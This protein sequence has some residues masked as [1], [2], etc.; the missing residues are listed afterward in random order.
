MNAFATERS[1]NDEGS[2]EG[3]GPI[4]GGF[5]S[6]SAAV[7]CRSAAAT[8]LE[9][10]L[11]R[12]L[13]SA[14]GCPPVEF[15]LWD[16]SLVAG[17]R[18]RAISALRVR[19]RR[20]FWKLI[21]NPLLQFGEGYS[22]G[23][24]EV[25][26]DL[27]EMLGAVYR[28][29]ARAGRHRQGRGFGPAL[30]FLTGS[31]GG[32]DRKS[33]HHHYDIG[34]DFYRLWLDEEMVYTC[35]YFPDPSMSLWEAQRAK[36]DHVCRKVRLLAGETVVEAGCGWGGLALHMARRYGVKVRAFNISREQI[37]YARQ[38][39]RREGLDGRVEFIEDD[40]RDITG[41]YD[42]FVSVGMLE[43]VGPRN[44]SRLGRII[45]RC[46]HASGRGLIHSIGRD[47]S[48]P[49]NRWIARRIFP[50]A[51]PP[52]LQ[53]ITRVFQPYD[54]SI[55]DVENLRLHYAQTLRHWLARYERSV[56]QVLGMFDERFAR[57]WRLYLAGSMAAFQEGRLQLFQIL[58]QRAHS[59][60]IPYSRR[61]MYTGEQPS[62]RGELMTARETWRGQ[63]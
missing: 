5:E 13:L 18:G 27:G 45:D 58:F 47:Y 31:T 17:D 15:I 29:L 53:E 24:I 22:E 55:L 57:M 21:C 60:Q 51:Y 7:S 52:T 19:D 61:Y 32:S 50:G 9:R 11:G 40:W 10:W 16:G 6:A 30:G 26:G 14:L 39:A 56:D 49:V 42:A 3:E 34:N 46:L 28:G 43:H 25:W 54:F 33:I 2:I 38:R 20:T 59:N 8:G 36:M 41:R 1:R 63:L 12:L 44:Y 35:A 62:A 23:S 4:S 48:A 37:C